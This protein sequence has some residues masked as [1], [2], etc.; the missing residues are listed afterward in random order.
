M[1]AFLEFCHLV[2][3]AVLDE[4]NLVAIDNALAWYHAERQIFQDEGIVDTFSLPRQHSM[5][6]YR[7]LIQEFAAP[8]GLCSSITES[9]HIKAVKE[10]WRRSSRFE[11]LRQMLII[12][13]RLDKL[14]VMCVYFRVRGMLAGT[15]FDP[16]LPINRPPSEEQHRKDD[17]DDDGSDVDVPRHDILGEVTLAKVPFP[18]KTYSRNLHIL[19][20][21]SGHPRLPE[22][23]RRFLYEQTTINP[24]HTPEDAPLELCPRYHGKVFTY[25]SAVAEFYAPSDLS[26]IGADTGLPGFRRMHVARALLFMSV[27]YWD[28]VYPCALVNWYSAVGTAPD[29]DTGLWVVTPDV[30]YNNRLVESVVH[31]DCLLRG[32]HLIGKLNG[33]EFIPRGMKHTDTLDIF[34]SFFVN[35]YADHHSHEIAF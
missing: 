35:K 10:P 22:L 21:E 30:D 16:P 17:E 15:W 19:A 28:M 11:A 26:G 33:N 13:E 5:V 32:A 12:N 29:P 8:N 27:R 14:A 7:H 31:V 2:W 1:A 20:R 3:R 24:T 9:K 34:P 18:P 23:L 6:H 4:D 25:P